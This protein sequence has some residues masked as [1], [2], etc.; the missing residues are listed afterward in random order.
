MM[1]GKLGECHVVSCTLGTYVSTSGCTPS[2]C[3]AAE[4][5]RSDLCKKR[6]EV[7]AGQ[8]RQA[9]VAPKA[10]ASGQGAMD[11]AEWHVPSWQHVSALRWSQSSFRTHGAH[12]SLRRCLFSACCC[13]AT[14]NVAGCRVFAAC[15]PRVSVQLLRSNREPFVRSH[16]LFFDVAQMQLCLRQ[17]REILCARSC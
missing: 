1:L 8:G 17:T 4:D 7:A 3:T 16:E 9:A 2:P 14:R 12:A 15:L 10:D 6:G 5:C 11:A 13:R